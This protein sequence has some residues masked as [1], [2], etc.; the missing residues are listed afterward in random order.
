MNVVWVI[1]TSGHIFNCEEDMDSW[2]LS[3]INIKKKVL[4]VCLTFTTLKSWRCQHH[5]SLTLYFCFHKTKKV[6]TSYPNPTSVPRATSVHRDRSG[7]EASWRDANE[8]AL[9]TSV[10]S[11]LT[12]TF[13]LLHFHVVFWKFW[14]WIE[15]KISYSFFSLKKKKK[16]KIHYFYLRVFV[17]VRACISADTH[18]STGSCES[19]NW[20]LRIKCGSFKSWATS[21]KLTVLSCQQRMA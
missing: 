13:G 3:L 5:W 1:M 19:L 20:V 2:C 10:T 21:P 4:Y 17:C 18:R 16:D 14:K 7:T 8:L 6:A 11:C 15:N 12:N 9:G